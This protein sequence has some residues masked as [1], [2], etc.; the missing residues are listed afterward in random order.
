[1]RARGIWDRTGSC[2]V[3]TGL[4]R[5]STGFDRVLTG[6]LSGFDRGCVAGAAQTDIT[7]ACVP[8]EG[9]YPNTLPEGRAKWTNKD[10]IYSGV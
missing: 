4:D 7:T 1:M 8:D 6:F 10:R 9:E 3:L 5:G 2:P